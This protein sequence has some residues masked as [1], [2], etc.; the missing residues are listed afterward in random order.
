MKTM[1]PEQA[2]FTLDAFYTAQKTACRSLI[3]RCETGEPFTREEGSEVL[4]VFSQAFDVNFGFL[5]HRMT[6]SSPL[7]PIS[8][9][10]AMSEKATAGLQELVQRVCG[11]VSPSHHISKPSQQ[12]NKG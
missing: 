10:M 8:E 5:R 7:I 12:S 6:L 2:Q 9:L 11:D 4:A 1:T 3:A